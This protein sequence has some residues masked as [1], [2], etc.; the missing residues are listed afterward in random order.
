MRILLTSM[1][2]YPARRGGNG[3]SRVLDGL[4][5][6][7]AELGQ[8]V[9]YCVSGGY[10]EP[11]PRGMMASRRDAADADL[12]HFNDYP[13]F[14]EPPP[15][16]KPWLRTFHAPYEPEFAPLISDHFIFVSRAQAKS[17]GSSRYVWNGA[18]PAE[19]LYSETKDDYFLF[20]VSEL[21]RAESKGLLTAIALVERLG[22]RLLVAALIDL[23]PLPPA[24]VSRNVTYLGEICDEEK[25]TLLAGAR[26]L[27]FPV[28]IDEAFGMVVAEALMSGTPVIGSKRGALTE[29]LTP[30]VGFTCDTLEDYVAAVE[31]LDRIEPAACRR[32]ALAEFDY[33][34]MARRYLVEYERELGRAAPCGP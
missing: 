34:V 21:S 25:A 23:H 4:A 32:R 2:R 24:F 17:F 9:L 19:F 31:R 20:I 26:A 14:G 22:T 28:Q 18:D 30:D 12:Y 11:L 10:A 1:S 16:G 7:L 8:T 5:K 3:S 13:M 33:R 29:L 27:L 15:A 6:G